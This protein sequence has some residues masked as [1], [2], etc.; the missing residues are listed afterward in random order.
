MYK[1]FPFFLKES[2]NN[3]QFFLVET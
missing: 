2:K 1:I 3:I